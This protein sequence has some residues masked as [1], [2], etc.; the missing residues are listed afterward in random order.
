MLKRHRA[1]GA[2][3]PPLAPELGFTRV[4][5]LLIG[6]SRIYPTSA[7]GIGRG[8]ATRSTAHAKRFICARSPPPHPPPRAGEGADRVRRSRSGIIC[9]CICITT[10]PQGRSDESEFAA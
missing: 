3:P 9:I 6:R 5:P 1:L 4:R 8:H 2:F 10:R 7:G